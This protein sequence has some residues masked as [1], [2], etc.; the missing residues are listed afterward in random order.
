MHG[1]Q[2]YEDNHLNI[3]KALGPDQRLGMNGT[4]EYS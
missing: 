1:R 4:H 3:A 2:D